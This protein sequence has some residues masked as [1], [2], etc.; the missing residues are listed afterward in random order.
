[1]PSTTA[2]KPAV[3]ERTCIRPASPVSTVVRSE[4]ELSLSMDEAD[5]AAGGADEKLRAVDYKVSHGAVDKIGANRIVGGSRSRVE[6]ICV[7]RLREGI[8]PPALCVI[9]KREVP[10]AATFA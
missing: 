9:P 7:L 8:K 2:A 4:S 6:L 10:A 3:P 1:M 5:H